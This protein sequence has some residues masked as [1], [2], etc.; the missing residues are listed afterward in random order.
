M[1]TRDRSR[2]R[3]NGKG[4]GGSRG[5]N[6][7]GFGTRSSVIAAAVAGAAVGL[8]ANFGR[9]ALVQGMGAA[10]G[11]WSDALAAEHKAVL[12]HFDALEATRDDQSFKRAHLL[13]KIKNALAKHALEE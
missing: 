12:A 4:G 3:T 8:A 11:D 13:T 2:T 10:A 6:A 1:A 7:F 9:K 5:D